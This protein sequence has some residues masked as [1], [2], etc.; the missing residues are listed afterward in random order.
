M[1]NSSP[2]L[3]NRVKDVQDEELIRASMDDFEI[4]RYI[5]ESSEMFA[6]DLLGKRPYENIDEAPDQLRVVAERL[7]SYSGD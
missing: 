2:Y 7:K 3:G 6:A 1:L 4:I 5:P